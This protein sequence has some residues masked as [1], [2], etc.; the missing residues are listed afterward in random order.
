[1]FRE[2]VL[3]RATG[4]VLLDLAADLVRQY[5]LF[6]D[7]VKAEKIRELYKATDEISARFGKHTLHLG[8]SHAIETK[9]A[10]KR[11]EPTVR[12]Q[13]KFLGETKRQHLGLPILHVK[14]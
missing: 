13:T 14:V 5:S 2:R 3:Y 8:A 7:P 6:E 1:M 4:I 12:E 11:G 9:G 10:G